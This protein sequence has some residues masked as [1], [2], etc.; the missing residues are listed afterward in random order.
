MVASMNE[1]R[2]YRI[3]VERQVERT[4]R[5]LPKDLL[6][7]IRAA[8]RRLAAEPRPTGCKKLAGYANLYRIRLGDWRIVY[9]IEDD[10]LL[11]L[12]L[13]IS[14]RGGAYRN[15]GD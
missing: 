8:I 6:D 3:Q 2:R 7:R 14:P 11:V 1:E 9:A 15:L 4:L 13:D 5:R 10:A 12:L